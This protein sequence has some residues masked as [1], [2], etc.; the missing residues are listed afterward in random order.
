MYLHLISRPKA[1]EL[2]LRYHFTGSTCINGN[3]DARYT[4]NG[5]CMCNPC[6][7]KRKDTAAIAEKRNWDTKLAR[8][9]RYRN[10]NREEIA[11]RMRKYSRENAHIR[12]DY[13]Q[14]NRCV[15]SEKAKKY[16][17]ENRALFNAHT[18]K[19]K[20]ERIKRT[21]PWYGHLDDF[22]MKEAADLCVAR[23]KSTGVIWHMDHAIPLRAVTA[24]GLHCAKNIQVIPGYVNKMKKNRM[25]ATEPY[26]WCGFI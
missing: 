5:G 17:R 3:I 12:A 10:K 21:P 13:V 23:E 22:V 24:S 11:G 25:M 4:A 7:Q 9:A 8:A 16:R 14:R 26:E 1:K 6:A 19:R 18:A 2:V 15:I 20:A